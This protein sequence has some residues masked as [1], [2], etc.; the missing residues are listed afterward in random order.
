MAAAL[1][2]VNLFPACLAASVLAESGRRNSASFLPTATKRSLLLAGPGRT[3]RLRVAATGPATPQKI[4]DKVSESIKKAEQTCEE[5][6]ES[7]ECAA[8]WD[9]VEELSAAASHARDR[10]KEADPLETFC[11]DN[12]E[13]VECRTYDS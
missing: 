13:T 1:S 8:A 11:T 4:S 10:A 7:G 12:P 9:E 6:A 3:A 2:G 5:N